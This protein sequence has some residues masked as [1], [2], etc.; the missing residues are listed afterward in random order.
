V[1]WL[2]RYARRLRGVFSSANERA[3]RDEL[4]L[5]V[6]LLA[7]EFRDQG[8]SEVEARRRADR[9]FG[10]RTRTV[11]LTR[12]VTTLPWLESVLNDVVY[13][14]RQLRRS[15]AVTILAVVSL[16]IGI[17]ANA[18][19]FSIV[20]ALVLRSLPV[21]APDRLA[22]L[23]LGDHEAAR[24]SGSRWS[25]AFWKAFEPHQTHFAGAMAWA[26]VRVTV[27]RDSIMQPVDGVF[28]NGGFFEALRLTV[29]LGRTLQAID[30]TEGA[31]PVVVI[32]HRY[33][34]RQFG[35]AADVVGRSILVEETPFTVVGV[36]PSGFDGLEIGQA[37][38]LILPLSAEALVR[39][40]ASNLRPPFDGM[41]MWLRIG[42]RLRSDQSLESG[43]AIARGLQPQLREASLPP[44]FPQLR[45]TLLREPIGLVSAANGLSRVRSLYRR[46]LNVLIVVVGVVLLL[47]CVNVANLLLAQA[48]AREQE[49][50][51]RL[52]LGASRG[53]VARQLLVESALL[54]CAGL[55]IGLLVARW[56]AQALVAQ[57]STPNS[58]VTLALS[59]DWRVIGVTSLL[60]VITT[61]TCGT[62]AALR[63]NSVAPARALSNVAYGATSSRR[64]RV[65]DTLLATQIALSLTLVVAAGLFVGT[66]IRLASVPLGF[67]RDAVLLANVGAAQAGV[68]QGQRLALYERLAE[69]VRAV[70]GVAQAAA[71]TM[72]LVS[73][74]NAPIVVTPVRAAGVPA[75]GGE[76]KSLFVTPGWVATYGLGIIAGRDFTQSD[77]ATSAPVMVVN[78]AFTDRYLD[79][80]AGV[81][82]MVQLALGVKAEYQLPR[83]TIVG[84]VE[85]A[86]YQSLREAP[87]PTAY[88]PLAQYDYPVPMSASI[89]INVRG[90]TGPV[91][92][93]AKD[94]TTAINGVNPRLT[95]TTR[96]L[97]SQ[98]MESIRQERILAEMSGLF[99]VMAVFLAA[100]GLFGIT[101]YSV[102]RRRREM[103]VRVAV[104]ASHRDVMRAVLGRVA[105]P[106]ALGLVAGTALSTWLLRLV[107][108]LFFGVSAGNPLLLILA[109]AALVSTAL[110][111]AWIPARRAHAVNSAGILRAS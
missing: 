73:A 106:I 102:A 83:R 38:D 52:A 15:P 11:E 8:F 59:L 29:S 23:S 67:D 101:T 84:V 79:G 61:I 104:G 3:V 54:T 66:F 111:A 34:Q 33:W 105:V 6:D 58:P 21:P 4:D 107:S 16:A 39:G 13:G 27:S 81:G 110:V 35:G 64:T 82:E 14:A 71:S 87:P 49:L 46:P 7:D 62:A 1:T 88:L 98:V 89:A 32:G 40:S 36:T 94:V 69:V 56:A 99:G 22:A 5:H 80:R 85:N 26:P 93:L 86:V 78:R 90:K 42:V 48:T 41:N 31:V 2:R 65:P 20:N 24:V 100:A 70:P 92:A 96:T 103:A 77:T 91:A 60:G 18:A 45:E 74:S 12:A 95:V 53:R 75:S 63:V 51:M 30:D 47:A 25:Y 109:S 19:V 72:T 17:G 55:A 97:A 37:A 43:G 108:A 28:V 68:P 9:V 10:N 50:G 76:A 44:A 57:L